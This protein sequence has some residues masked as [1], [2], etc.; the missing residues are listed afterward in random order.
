[1]IEHTIDLDKLM[2]KFKND[3]ITQQIKEQIE[4]IRERNAQR[5]QLK[6]IK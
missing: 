4:R 1:M 3:P 2:E 5:K 6:G